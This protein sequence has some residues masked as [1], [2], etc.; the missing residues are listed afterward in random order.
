MK[1]VVTRLALLADG[2]WLCLHAHTM[3]G[4]VLMVVV[5]RVGMFWAATHMPTRDTSREGMATRIGK[6]F[7][8]RHAECGLLPWATRQP[9]LARY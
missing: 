5:G 2:G 6:L 1:N 7:C 8:G 4:A 3:S 9:P